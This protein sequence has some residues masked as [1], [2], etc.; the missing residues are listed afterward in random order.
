MAKSEEVGGM[1]FE[2]LPQ[3]PWNAEM[4]HPNSGSW[5]GQVK[6][7]FPKKLKEKDEKI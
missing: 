6:L 5:E 3:Q 4:L 2:F 1:P 7:G